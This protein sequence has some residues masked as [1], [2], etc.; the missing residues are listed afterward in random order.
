MDGNCPKLFYPYR[1]YSSPADSPDAY[2]EHRL[3]FINRLSAESIW[4]PT[5]VTLNLEAKL[6]DPPL[7]S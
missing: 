2:L 3:T 7:R 4:M 5:K 1:V 6:L